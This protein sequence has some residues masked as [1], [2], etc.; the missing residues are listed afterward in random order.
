MFGSAFCRTF[1]DR[2]EIA[3]IFHEHALDVIHG[4]SK[5][6][7]P[8]APTVELAE[9]KNPPFAIRADL[10]Q[11]EEHERVLE[12][13]FARFGQIDVVINA[14]VSSRWGSM[15]NSKR[16]AESVEDQFRLSVFVPFRLCTLLM[17]RY[18][19]LDV[20]TNRAL[21]RNIVNMSSTSATHL[22]ARQGQSVYAAAKAALNV[23]TVHMAD[24][25][26][27]YGIR[28]NALSPDRFGTKVPLSTVLQALVNLDEG[29]ATGKIV[30]VQH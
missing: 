3:G 7:D 21:N 9:N 27:L 4:Q 20:P 28:V 2:Y 1:S 18:W 19:R 16:L 24:E 22:Y 30:E 17:R 26:G 8:L 15:V 29:N 13:T 11:P 25:F 14:A 10:R 12:L 5:L 6:I 23:L